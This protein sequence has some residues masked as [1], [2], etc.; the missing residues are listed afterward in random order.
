[1]G[2]LL[3]IINNG[4]EKRVRRP[5]K[6]IKIDTNILFYVPT[7]Q[8]FGLHR[9]AKL[10]HVELFITTGTL[11]KMMWHLLRSLYLE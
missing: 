10:K 2:K 6:Q 7:S 5:H 3:K 8:I 11:P 9:S 4:V 1:M